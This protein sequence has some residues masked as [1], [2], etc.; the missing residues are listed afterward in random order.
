MRV[1]PRPE[2]QP[3]ASR[4]TVP[5]SARTGRRVGRLRRLKRNAGRSRVKA[6]ERLRCVRA[7]ADVFHAAL[8]NAIQDV[9]RGAFP[10][11]LKDAVWEVGL[12]AVTVVRVAVE[13]WRPL[14]RVT[15]E[16]R[17]EQAM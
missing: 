1:S 17:R 16:G 5:R 11:A 6:I 2:P 15:V 7:F 8:L 4:S 12:T 13:V 3:F 9:F 14:V 10:G